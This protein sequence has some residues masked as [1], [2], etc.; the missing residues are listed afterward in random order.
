M[1]A[2]TPNLWIWQIK[3]KESADKSKDLSNFITSNGSYK[4]PQRVL[5]VPLYATAEQKT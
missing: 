1:F 4:N 2:N 5:A 3:W